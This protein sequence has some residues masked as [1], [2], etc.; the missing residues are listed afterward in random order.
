[1]AA[2]GLGGENVIG[3]FHY[4]HFTVQYLHTGC[5]KNKLLIELWARI[6]I[7]KL[8]ALG[9]NFAMN[10]TWEHLIMLSLSK[11]RAKNVFFNRII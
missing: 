7:T 4:F 11:K 10:I 9:P 2:S 6:N 5:L 8:V 1:M 3:L